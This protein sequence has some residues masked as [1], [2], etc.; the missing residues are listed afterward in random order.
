MAPKDFTAIPVIDMAGLLSADPAAQ[1]VVADEMGRAA[2]DVGFFY[3][4]G[5]GMDPALFD[6]VLAAAQQFFEQPNEAKLANYIGN[7]RNHRGYVPEGEEIFAGKTSDLKEAYD[8]A[9]DLP[10]DDPDYLAGNPM[11][12]P[13][14]WPDLPGFADQVD[15]YYQGVR[16]VGTHVFRGL[17]LGLGEPA[18]YFDDVTRKPP[19]QLRLIH[20]PVDETAAS[21]PGI[22]DHTDY[23]AFTLLR[24]TSPGLEVLAGSGHWV[25]APPMPDAFVV[26]IGD[27][28]ELWTNGEYVATTHRVR[29]V[30]QERWSFPLFFSLDYD[31]LVTPME[32][33]AA[34]GRPVLE[35]LV[36]GEH[37]FA[38]TAQSFVYL[39]QRLAA[40]EITLPEKSVGLSSF[41]Q[42][43][44]LKVASLAM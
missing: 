27:M 28:L 18:D 4:T 12:G 24:S 20:Y 7:S 35:P 8:L 3:L 10:A 41:G 33:F 29:A 5:T 42:E 23:E 40:G 6:G 26:N 39:Q 13:N 15:A 2:R 1:Q 34:P 31:T 30:E 11:L 14:Q 22:G 38:Q 36:A 32:R 44:R 25:D 21:R 17:A 16:A 43:T 37:L 19:S 9:A